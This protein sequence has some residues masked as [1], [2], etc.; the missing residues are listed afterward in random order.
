M[1]VP[2]SGPGD[3][4][5]GFGLAPGRIA[6]LRAHAPDA[7]RIVDKMPPNFLYL[8]FI[9]TILAGTRIIHCRRHPLDTCL[10]LFFPYFRAGQPY[11]YSLERLGFYCR[12][13]RRRMAHWRAVLPK[14]MLELDY[15][16]LVDDRERESRRL[17][18][19]CG[20][21]WGPRCRAFHETER[22]ARTAEPVAGATAGLPPLGG[23]RWRRYQAHLQP[24]KDALGPLEMTEGTRPCGGDRSG[25]GPAGTGFFRNHHGHVL[26]NCA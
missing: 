26:E 3:R 8:G 17:I 16:A 4:A 1:T 2:R 11:A 12:E 23:P 7:A 25:P 15:G 5:H 13:Y 21:P 14:A 20:L 18:E 22:A 19:F 6:L 24:P 9:A 10:W